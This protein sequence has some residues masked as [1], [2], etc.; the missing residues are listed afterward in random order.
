MAQIGTFISES[1]ALW[2][3]GHYPDWS[4]NDLDL[5]TTEEFARKVSDWLENAS[6]TWSVKT[7]TLSK[8]IMSQMLNV[9]IES[10]KVPTVSIQAW[11]F[12]YSTYSGYG[13]LDVLY[14]MKDNWKIQVIVAKGSSR[15]LVS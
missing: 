7:E 13:I 5:Y 10:L 4:P 15:G 2:F 6:Y 3:M 8:W 11:Y 1:F 12:T 14:Y 9:S